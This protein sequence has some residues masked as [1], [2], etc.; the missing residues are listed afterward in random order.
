M[1]Y[2]TPGG[3]RYEVP[4]PHNLFSELRDERPRLSPELVASLVLRLEAEI[5]IHNAETQEA[6]EHLSHINQI[7]EAYH[8][9][10]AALEKALDD[11]NERN[12]TL[13]AEANGQAGPEDKE[14]Q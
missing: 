3:A 7:A 5:V 6:Y 12:E 9:R 1:E 8:R 14:G 4:E 2:T 10:V 13:I 11:A